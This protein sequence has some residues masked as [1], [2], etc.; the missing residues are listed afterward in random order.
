MII[1][2]MEGD[3]GKIPHGKLTCRM[4][5][6]GR[7]MSQRIIEILSSSPLTNPFLLFALLH[8]LSHVGGIVVV[9]HTSHSI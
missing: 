9:D 1:R 7:K 8:S 6:G 2:G 3:A 5:L 4:E